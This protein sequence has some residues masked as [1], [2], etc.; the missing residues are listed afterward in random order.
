M[1]LM[2][3]H[4]FRNMLQWSVPHIYGLE[5]TLGDTDSNQKDLT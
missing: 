4:V 3:E 1:E 5:R 2:D